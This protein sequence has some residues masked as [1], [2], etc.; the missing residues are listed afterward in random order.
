MRRRYF[1]P[2]HI[3]LSKVALKKGRGVLMTFMAVAGTAV[4]VIGVMQI[5]SKYTTP[6]NLVQA[7][8]PQVL[9]AQDQVGSGSNLKP[10]DCPAKTP[11]KGKVTTSGEKIY[12]LVSDEIYKKIRPDVC[13]EDAEKASSAGFAPSSSDKEQSSSG[14]NDSA[15]LENLATL[16]D[17]GSTEPANGEVYE[18]VLDDAK[19][20]VALENSIPQNS[21]ESITAEAAAPKTD[22]TTASF[23]TF[24]E[25][26]LSYKVI[27]VDKQKQELF[28]LNQGKIDLNTKVTTG[29]N[30]FTT[31]A[32]EFSIKNKARNIRLK[33]PSPR[34]GNYNLKVQYWLGLG[35]GYG[36]HDAWWRKSFGG[37]DYHYNG[38]HGCV[39]MPLEAVKTIYDWA[40]VGTKVYII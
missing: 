6:E 11:V 9:S 30:G 13:F 25:E 37:E 27:V 32:G 34:F 19:S 16:N 4:W 24:L 7:P 31:P 12:Y 3:S 26:S 15:N 18:A 5:T 38:S 33:A 20:D 39:N 29:K 2:P 22:L 40:E 28:A 23:D 10:L 8:Q 21:S 35:D 36:L 17:Q 14:V 1:H